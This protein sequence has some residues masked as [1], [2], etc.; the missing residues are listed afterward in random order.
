[1]ACCHPPWV[2][3]QHCHGGLTSPAQQVQ[4]LDVQQLLNCQQLCHSP[5]S[6]QAGARRPPAPPS[7]CRPAASEQDGMS[8][9]LPGGLPVAN[10]ELYYSCSEV[11][12]VMHLPPEVGSVPVG[13]LVEASGPSQVA[14]PAVCTHSLTPSL[15]FLM[16]ECWRKS[17]SFSNHSLE[18]SWLKVV[19][20]VPAVIVYSIQKCI[21]YFQSC[22]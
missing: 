19:F 3:L 13:I 11:A 22:F 15:F 2:G 1:M 5:W 10:F 21:E 18:R 6:C 20:N 8:K 14:S 12:E 9:N 7:S 17:P 4:H 16:Q